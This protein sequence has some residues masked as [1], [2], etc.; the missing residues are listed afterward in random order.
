MSQR[1]IKLAV[2]NSARL[3]LANIYCTPYYL[4][5]VTPSNTQMWYLDE[6]RK[7]WNTFVF[8]INFCDLKVHS[9]Q[10]HIAEKWIMANCAESSVSQLIYNDKRVRVRKESC[11][12]KTSRQKHNVMEHC[13]VFSFSHPPWSLQKL[14]MILFS[15]CAQIN[16]MFHHYVFL[17]PF[18]SGRKVGSVWRAEKRDGYFAF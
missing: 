2:N 17:P 9:L 10:F 3:S 14:A 4:S 11:L 1:V 12:A 7:P 13:K 6:V 16:N 15:L 8:I 5:D 18:I